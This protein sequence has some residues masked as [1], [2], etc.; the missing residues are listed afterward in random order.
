MEPFIDDTIRII[1]YI[2]VFFVT[3]LPI[4]FLIKI[5]VMTNNVKRMNKKMQQMLDIMTE[6][7]ARQRTLI[8][9]KEERIKQAKV[10]SE[11]ST[12][13]ETNKTQE[14]N[15]DHSAYMPHNNPTA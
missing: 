13:T 8:A 2:I 5:W 11:E 12:A 14:T 4:I 9:L 6:E 3:I 15:T 10:K 7:Q 1:I